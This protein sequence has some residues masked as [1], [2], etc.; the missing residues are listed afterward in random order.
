MGRRLKESITSRY[1]EAANRLTSKDARRRIIAY[2]E[3]YDDVFFWRTVLGGLEDDTCYFEIMLPSK[4]TLQRGKKSVLMSVIA[5]NAGK[6]MIACV[7]ADY[8]YLMQGH[9]ISSQKVLENPFVF[10]TYVYSIEN[11]QCY[12][13]A[14]R[15][16]CVM[17]TL[18]DHAIFD[19]Y[20]YMRQF[21]ETCYPLFV[22]SVWAYRTGNYNY[23]SLTD[24]TKVIEPGKF[25]I[26]TPQV[27]ID[28]LRH[29]VTRRVNI[30]KQHFPKAK[31][32]YLALKAE[33]ASIGVTPQNTYLYI[34]GHH[35][36]DAVV[37]P[38]M[39]KVCNYLRME[40]EKEIHVT[41]THRTQMRNE[42]SCYENSIEDVRSMLKKN[43]GYMSSQ[44]FKKLQSDVDAFVK[45][46]KSEM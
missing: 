39:T 7:D 9:T 32:S 1:F 3:S 31:E 46:L 42:L 33:L 11:F 44:Q 40:R 26:F 19:F 6:D 28:N 38:I 13:P 2:V 45:K 8:D 29:K 12:A 14:L 27:S 5:D 41:S 30:L 35:I 34:Q 21:S 22:W 10:H 17:V 16:V 15:N 37:V 4:G 20:D 23:F 24:F 25:N 43:V 18:N 36:F